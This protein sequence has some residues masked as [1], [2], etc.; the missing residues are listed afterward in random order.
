MSAKPPSDNDDQPDDTNRRDTPTESGFGAFV[1]DSVRRS[2][3]RFHKEGEE[4]P[5]PRRR[6]QQ[7]PDETS[8]PE[9][10]AE[11]PQP[12]ARRNRGAVRPGERQRHYVPAPAQEPEDTAEQDTGSAAAVPP[13]A[14]D[15]IDRA[16]G[17]ERAIGILALLLVALVALI[18][19]LSSVLGGDD[20]DG[21]PTPTESLQVLPIG[22]QG[23]PSGATDEEATPDDPVT[24]DD[25][26]PTATEIADDEGTG[27]SPT[28]RGS[29]NVLDRLPST[30]AADSRSPTASCDTDCLARVERTPEAAQV[31]TSNGTRPSYTGDNW[32]WVVAEPEEIAD[33]SSDLAT[34]VVRESPDTLR[35]YMVVLPSAEASDDA[36]GQLGNVIDSVGAYRLVES[37]TAPADVRSVLDA[38]LVVEKVAPATLEMRQRAD[39]LPQLSEDDIAGMI[40]DVDASRIEETIGD[41]QV[42]GAPDGGTIGTRHYRTPGNQAAAEYLYQK[43]ES[44]GLDVW[45]EDFVSWDG[46]LL[47]N[48]VGEIPGRDSSQLY[49]IMAHFDTISDSSATAAPGA[50]DNASGVAA[51]LEIARVLA[52]YDLAYSLRVVFVN[53]EEEGVV[54]SQEFARDAIQAGDPW[55]GIFNIDSVGSGRNGDQIVLNADGSSIW[56]EELIQR[57]DDAYGLA[58][59]L[60]MHQ[61]DEI[62]ADDSRL[63]D[64]GIE[65]VLVARE[66]YGWSPVHH[67]ADDVVERVS[68][69]HTE[70]ASVLILLTVGSLL[71]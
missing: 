69:P 11:R 19:L 34:E 59:T 22:D 20:G 47:V 25:P 36:V 14:Q 9:K 3:S 68:I 45:Y 37:E 38:G 10:S 31:L 1:S 66:L 15:A 12:A 30:P 70:R 17:T 43:L 5:A 41:L 24:D 8:D 26:V 49:G 4:A 54:G 27:E 58:D 16:G 67:T 39:G 55:E 52:E 13:W 48:V 18:W 35:L 32:Y 57:V 46:L 51:S 56:M 42:T 6:R 21:D 2:A 50:D 62:V 40:N 33:I 63:R 71:V 61:S 7:P 60:V 28:R 64:E 65:A 29:D 23:T 53:Y 44:Y